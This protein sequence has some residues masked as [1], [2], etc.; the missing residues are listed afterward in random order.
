M[1]IAPSTNAN[2][3]FYELD[4]V[5]FVAAFAVMLTHYTYSGYLNGYVPFE[6]PAVGGVTRYG[7]FGLVLLFMISGFVI[8]MTAQNRSWSGFVTSRAVRLYPTYWICVSLTALVV[9]VSNYEPVPMS[10]SKYLA[11]LTLLQSGLGFDHIDGVYWTLEV[12]L[13]FY[14]WVFVVCLFRLMPHIQKLLGL[15]LLA[16]IAYNVLGG[17]TFTDLDLLILPEWSCYFI[18]GAAF[19]LIH[20][21]GRS[22]YLTSLVV[23]SCILA[24]NLITVDP[25]NGNPLIAMAGTLACFV[26]FT[27]MIST[28]IPAIEKPWVV[29]LGAL[30]YPLYLIHQDIGYVVLAKTYESVPLYVSIPLVVV[31]MIVASHFLAGLIEQRCTAPFKRLVVWLLSLVGAR[32]EKRGARTVRRSAPA[33]MPGRLDP[34]EG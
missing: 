16:S 4:L 27:V 23:A 11:N 21:H 9:F 7:Y 30:T 31:S 2:R 15:W 29:T 24:L 34:V 26:F 17:I 33:D 25:E 19:F 13:V 6:V 12:E 3:R 22:L 1:G 20:Q 10:L 14:A 18:S 5:R 32:N 8:L 28:R